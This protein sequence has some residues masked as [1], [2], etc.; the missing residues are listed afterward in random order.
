MKVL[1]LGG[2]GYL[3][4]CVVAAALARRYEVVAAYRG[5]TNNFPCPAGAVATKLDRMDAIALQR[6]ASE[7]SFDAVL[8]VVPCSG[9]QVDLVAS[10][11]GGRIGK[12]VACSSM[13]VYGI[14]TYF[15]TDESHPRNPFPPWAG[16]LEAEDSAFRY[17][18]ASGISATVLRVPYLVGEGSVLIDVWGNKHPGFIQR[19]IDRKPITVPD[20]GLKLFQMGHIEDVAQAFVRAI[21]ADASAGQAYN[22][23]QAQAITYNRHLEILGD[24]LNREPEIAH[25]PARYLAAV[26]GG[27]GGKLNL[28]VFNVNWPRHVCCD[29]SKAASDLGFHAAI[30]VREGL[31]RS[32]HWMADSGKI[33][34]P[35]DVDLK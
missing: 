29:V 23:G 17:G 2:T 1:I 26:Y 13:A 35:A 24:L 4:H 31:R 14:A 18:E 8:D 22:I 34:L 6:L 16:K 9:E 7:H 11:F 21:E 19:I 27:E 32:L 30:D 20:S 10:A 15:P 25:V 12:Y 3:G 28:D 5:V 33:V